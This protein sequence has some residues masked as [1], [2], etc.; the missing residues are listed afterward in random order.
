MSPL[1]RTLTALT[2]LLTALTTMAL[3][4]S[5]A[6]AQ[7]LPPEPSHARSTPTPAPV[8]SGF[9]LWT[10]LLTVIVAFALILAGLAFTVRLR[11]A[12]PQP[13]DA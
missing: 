12:Q 3:L 7:V 2:G 1:R 9:P 8:S 10:V 6:S 11:H 13:A 4:A 5:A